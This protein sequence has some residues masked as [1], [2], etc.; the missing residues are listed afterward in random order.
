VNGFAHDCCGQQ[1]FASSVLL[2]TCKSSDAGEQF[3]DL[4]GLAH[5]LW[6]RKGSALSQS[7]HKLLDTC[8]AAVQDSVVTVHMR[9]ALR[10]TAFGQQL[11]GLL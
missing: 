10:A 1:C 6:N 8:R 2:A 11:L 4:N 5:G 7:A 3:Q 9:T